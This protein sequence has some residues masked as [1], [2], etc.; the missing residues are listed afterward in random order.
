M[1]VRHQSN[2][3]IFEILI[4]I[5]TPT[6][7]NPH[8]FPLTHPFTHLHTSR[9]LK[10][11]IS[12][13]HTHSH[14][15]HSQ[16]TPSRSDVN[17]IANSICDGIDGFILTE[18]MGNGNFIMTAIS[19]AKKIATWAESTIYYRHVSRG[20]CIAGRANLDPEKT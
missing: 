13:K 19:Q 8:P 4:P 1:L 14:F 11:P 3:I 9:K 15:N 2:K 12:H 20:S 16:K 18:E 6:P 7:T 5:P 10:L 17:D